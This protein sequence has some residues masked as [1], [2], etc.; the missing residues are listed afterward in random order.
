MLINSRQ[1]LPSLVPTQLPDPIPR[2]SSI[3]VITYDFVP[4]L[5]SLLQNPKLMTEENW[6]L[7]PTDPLKKFYPDDG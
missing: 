3:D 2:M 1:M 7:D 5:L 6:V 4:Q